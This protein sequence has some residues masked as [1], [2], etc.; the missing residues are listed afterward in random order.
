MD[1]L[2]D[3]AHDHQPTSFI[4]ERDQASAA[5]M[6]TAQLHARLDRI[7]LRNADRLPAD[8]LTAIDALGPG[9]ERSDRLILEA[10]TAVRDPYQALLQA[11][12][13]AFRAAREVAEALEA[14]GAEAREGSLELIWEKSSS[15]ASARRG[16]IE[17]Q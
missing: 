7:R 8:L 9:L 14:S 1:V 2:I 15:Y 12:S 11:A 16:A 17:D 5:V 13:T 3:A 4:D 10:R 6:D